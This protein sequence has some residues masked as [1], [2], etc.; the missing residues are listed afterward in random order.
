MVGFVYFLLDDILHWHHNDLC[1][2]ICW[3]LRSP[4]NDRSKKG[5]KEGGEGEKKVKGTGSACLKN[6]SIWSPTNFTANLITSTVIVWP[7][8]YSRVHSKHRQN[9]RCNILFNG[10]CYEASALSSQTIQKFIS[11]IETRLASKFLQINNRNNSY[12]TEVPCGKQHNA[13]SGSPRW[14]EFIVD[15]LNV[16][17]GKIPRPKLP[18]HP[19]TPYT[20]VVNSF[21]HRSMFPSLSVIASWLTVEH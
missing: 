15:F 16:V 10:K 8:F 21:Y 12:L 20:L 19:Y 14:Q 9:F 6:Q 11:G 17:F 7:K 5:G 2:R 3:V 18:G 4:A 1:V 13:T